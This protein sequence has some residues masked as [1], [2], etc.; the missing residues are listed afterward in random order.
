MSKF[1]L[2]DI[3]ILGLSIVLAVADMF[4]YGNKEGALF[5]TVLGVVMFVGIWL[6][7]IILNLV[8]ILPTH[9]KTDKAEKTQ[10][11]E[12]V[13]LVPEG[14]ERNKNGLLALTDQKLHFRSYFF[15]KKKTS[16]DYDLSEIKKVTLTDKGFVE[17]YSMEVVMRSKATYQFSIYAGKRWKDAFLA[18]NV[19]VEWVNA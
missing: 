13:N 9:F 19:S 6:V 14:E 11:G 4:F 8:I 12:L 10:L 16:I 2:F 18:Q 3:R 1:I 5:S 17:R 15:N 7:W